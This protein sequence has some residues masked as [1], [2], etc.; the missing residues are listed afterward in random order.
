M[1]A[2]VIAHI[3]NEEYILPWWLKHHKK[4]FDHGIIIDYASTDK[5]IEIIK[6]ICP[7]WE[8]VQSRNT[9]FNAKL[10]DDEVLEYERK[11]EGWR[12]CLNV[13]EFLVGDHSK[14]LIDSIRS[15]QHLIPTITFWDWNPDGEL[16]RTK[17]LWE[18]KKQGIHYKTDFMARR[19]R[20]LHN[21]KTMQYDVGRHFPALNNE[22][23]VIFHYANCVS[24]PEMLKRRLQIQTK[25][26]QG[27]I[28]RNMGHQHHNY[29]KGLTEESLKA[30]LDAEQHKVKDQSNLIS[31]YT[32]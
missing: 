21:V 6:E 3:Y 29:G 14:F 1:T 25:I 13:T 19:A 5:S 12:I 20:S 31:H 16:D 11:I 9:E 28:A 22:E 7:T 8:V 15:T 24:S 26:P 17:P 18:Q 32:K 10:V 30:M 2:T 23:M 4:I 27:D